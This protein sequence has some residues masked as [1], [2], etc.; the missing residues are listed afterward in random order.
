M[1]NVDNLENKNEYT[2]K[3]TIK[4]PRKPY[5]TFWLIFFS[6]GFLCLS[7]LLKVNNFQFNIF[8]LHTY[9]VL[10]P[11]QPTFFHLIYE[12]ISLLLTLYNRFPNFLT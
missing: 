11:L 7:M 4:L 3:R 6:V 12:Y 2:K 8:I 5:S 10:T 1:L 9:T